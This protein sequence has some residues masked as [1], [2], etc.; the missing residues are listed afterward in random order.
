MTLLDRAVVALTSALAVACGDGASLPP[1]IVVTISDAGFDAVSSMLGARCG[2][3]D[4]HGQVGRPLRIYSSRG[5]R[6]SAKD[7]SGHG[8][9]RRAEHQANF[10]AVIGLEPETTF[11][12]FA[13]GGTRPERLLVVRKPT[14]LE[15]HE[16][17][18][19]LPSGEDG[20]ACLV[21]FFRGAVDEPRC[22][23]AEVAGRPE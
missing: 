9:T 22:S 8:G 17:G 5:L 6:L 10:D 12:V 20:I 2:T 3:L 16:G 21:S 18:L 11:A 7:S 19:V 14:L 1:D 15:H 23:N 13:E 4:C